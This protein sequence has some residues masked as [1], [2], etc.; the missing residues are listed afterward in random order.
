MKVKIGKSK[1]HGK[2]VIASEDIKKGE[3]IFN[4]RGKKVKYLIDN[5]R[6]AL[7][8]D[9]N[10]IGF[11]K[12]V[13]IKPI[14]F[15]LFYNHSCNPNSGILEKTKVIAMRDIKKGEEIT[16]DYSLSE[17]D[18]FWHIKC[19]CGSKNC[20]KNI[21]SIQFLPQK[22]F[23][24]YKQFIPD[25]FQQVFKNF[26]ISKFKSRR[27]LREVWTNFIKKDFGV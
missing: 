13:W 19:N 7:S 20:R 2:G 18:I 22:T 26:N 16:F 9:F 1:L 4:I 21:Y 27:G 11:G 23:N 24:K 3:H 25:Y 10:L 15:G 5:I 14:S 8:I 17:A 12:N 6:K